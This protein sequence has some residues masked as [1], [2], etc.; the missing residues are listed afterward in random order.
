M[1]S[2]HTWSAIADSFKLKIHLES[3]RNRFHAVAQ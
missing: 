2:L 1:P 3:P